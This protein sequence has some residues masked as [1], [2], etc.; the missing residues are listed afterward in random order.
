M[1]F[2]KNYVI[3]VIILPVYDESEKNLHISR[4]RSSVNTTSFRIYNTPIIFAER[5]EEES[6]VIIARSVDKVL[7]EAV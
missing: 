4:F 5:N 3:C 7:K 6:A 1:F 2:N